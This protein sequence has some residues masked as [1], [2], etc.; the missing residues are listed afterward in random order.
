M[1]HRTAFLIVSLLVL[2][3]LGAGCATS[4][5]GDAHYPGGPGACYQN[6]QQQRMVMAAF[7]TMGEYSSGCVCA[8]APAGGQQPPP[9][10]ENSGSLAVAAAPA[11]VGVVMQMRAQEEQN[12]RTA[13]PVR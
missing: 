4:F 13:V 9:S 7:V 10:A 2:G 6:C 1:N 11:A 8:P 12:A 3:A 5:T